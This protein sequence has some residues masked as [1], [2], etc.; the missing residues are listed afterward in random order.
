MA[1]LN[2]ASGS[3]SS[4]ATTRKRASRA[5]PATMIHPMMAI[6][7]GNRNVQRLRR[8][9]ARLGGGG[10]GGGRG[11]S[12]RR[13]VRSRRVVRSRGGASGVVEGCQDA[14]GALNR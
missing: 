12:V 9:R 14:G 3:R 7:S 4:H 6:H 11:I 5:S 2:T 8:R 13:G 10:G 1:A